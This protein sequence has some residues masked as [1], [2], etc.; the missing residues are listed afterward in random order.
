MYLKQGIVLKSCGVSVK[1]E[2]RV[3]M[4]ALSREVQHLFLSLNQ[5]TTMSAFLRSSWHRIQCPG[6]GVSLCG[7]LPVASVKG[8]KVCSLFP[9]AL[10]NK[11]VWSTSIPCSASEQICRHN[12]L[13]QTV[14]DHSDPC[15]QSVL[16]VV[17]LLW[18]CRLSVKGRGGWNEM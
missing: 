2:P 11:H 9:I 18:Y 10:V 6:R 7:S 5:T 13:F 8:R 1:G 16:L 15:S 4:R 3:S 12:H 17:D 14:E